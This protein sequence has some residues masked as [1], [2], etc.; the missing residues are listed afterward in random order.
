[1]FGCHTG[2]WVSSGFRVDIE[3]PS[4]GLLPD[5]KPIMDPLSGE[6][7]LFESVD[8]AVLAAQEK[9]AELEAE[10]KPCIAHISFYTSIM[11]P[12][13]IVVDSDGKYELP[14][15]SCIKMHNWRFGGGGL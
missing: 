12:I 15:E 14:S 8:E 13:V 3:C 6:V 10:G 11:K 4:E 5:S 2:G 1:M 9:L 7:K